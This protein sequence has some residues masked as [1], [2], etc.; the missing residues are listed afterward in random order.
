MKEI[1]LVG[2]GGS[3]G[4][5]LRFWISK[6][7]NRPG[8]YSFPLSTFLVNILGCLLIGILMGYFSKQQQYGQAA[9]RLL[10]VTG[11]CGGFTTFSAFASENLQLLQSGQYGILFLYILSSIVTGIG[12]AGFGWWMMQQG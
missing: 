12:L 2:L 9:Y 8:S 3:L 5:I 7:V 4:S 11:F 1:L 10:L 6:A